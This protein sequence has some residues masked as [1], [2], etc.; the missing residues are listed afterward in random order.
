M[1]T[2]KSP[3]SPD[4]VAIEHI[5]PGQMFWVDRNGHARLWSP[6]PP[7]AQIIATASEKLEAGDVIKIIDGKVIKA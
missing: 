4:G 3:D 7:P 5:M 6:K 1:Y 2:E